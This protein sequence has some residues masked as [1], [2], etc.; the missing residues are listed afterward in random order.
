MF[1]Y[2]EV[3]GNARSKSLVLYRSD[4]AR[5]ARLFLQNHNITN[6]FTQVHTCDVIRGVKATTGLVLESKAGAAC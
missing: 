4:N 3:I 5:N 6:H 1:K 2:V